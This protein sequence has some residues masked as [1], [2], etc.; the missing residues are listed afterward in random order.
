V[1]SACGTRPASTTLREGD[2]VCEACAGD[3]RLGAIL[4]RSRFLAWLESAGEADPDSSITILPGYAIQAVRELPSIQGASYLIQ[5]L[6]DFALPPSVLPIAGRYIATHVPIDGEGVARDFGAIAR[7]AQGA[8][9]LA[10]VKADVD[11]LGALFAWGL[12]RD[13]A[14][15]ADTLARSLALSRVVDTFFT[16]WVQ[17]LLSYGYH[18]CYTIYSGGDDLLLVGPWDEA[19]RLLATLQKDFRQYTAHPQITLSAGVAII[20]SNTP[21]ADAARVADEQ[22][23]LAKESGPTGGRNQLA[24]FDQVLSWDRA[25]VL[26]NRWQGLIGSQGRIPGSILH[27]WLGYAAAY[28]QHPGAAGLRALTHFAYDFARNSRDLPQDYREEWQRMLSSAMDGRATECM[29]ELAVLARLLLLSQRG[30]E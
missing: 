5:S 9:L 2:P 28:Q 1:C 29:A 11:R 18:N 19:L 8:P 6:N 13:D 7:D 26:I 17:G 16:G 14:G 15:T 10:V 12:R 22:E 24:I 25:L 20:R 21:I 27:R 23:A 3:Y 4:P 30:R